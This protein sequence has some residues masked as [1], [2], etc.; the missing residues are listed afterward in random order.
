ME[1]I[2][3]ITSWEI[4]LE[5]LDITKQDLDVYL[6]QWREEI[7]FADNLNEKFWQFEEAIEIGKISS[8]NLLILQ[9][10]GTRSTFMLFFLCAYLLFD[11]LWRP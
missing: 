4:I 5:N 10:R 6:T 8:I 3:L 2:G 9:R 11:I 7:P 1:G